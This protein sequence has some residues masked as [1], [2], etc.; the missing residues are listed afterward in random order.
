MPQKDATLYDSLGQKQRDLAAQ[1]H[2]YPSLC[3]A[4]QGKYEL[5]TVPPDFSQG[6]MFP[7]AGLVF[8]KYQAFELEPILGVKLHPRD[9][10]TIHPGDIKVHADMF[11]SDWRCR[12]G[13]I[14]RCMFDER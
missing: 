14:L 6:Q 1:Y 10:G 11:R 9:D 4:I 12:E 3:A 5:A 13:G 7:R 2:H 8:T